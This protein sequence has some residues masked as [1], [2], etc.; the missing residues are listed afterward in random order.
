MFFTTILPKNV[1]EFGP[2]ERGRYIHFAEIY[3]SFI[4]PLLGTCRIYHHAP[5][6]ASG[7]VESGD[8]LAMEFTSRDK[9]RGWATVIHLQKAE[10]EYLFRPKGVDGKLQYMVT[11]D[12]TGA[13]R[14]VSGERLKRE[15]TEIHAKPDQC[16]ELL[17][18]EAVKG[19]A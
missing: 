12:S 7:G 16:S 2:E 10:G 6:N 15:G 1:V 19:R 5:V 4:R 11:F 18:F 3:R 13:R 9:T 17:L 8:W 14:A